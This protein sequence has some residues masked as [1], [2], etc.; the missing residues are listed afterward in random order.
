M[1]VYLLNPPFK[2]GFVRCGRWQGSTARG[3]TLDYPKWLSYTYGQLDNEGFKVRL[4][5]AIAAKYDLNRIISDIE[6]FR[7]DLLIIET[8]FSSMKND[9]MVNGAIKIES[10]N[11]DIISVLTGPPTVVYPNEILEDTSVNIIARY[12]YDFVVRDLAVALEYGKQLKDID[13]IWYKEGSKIICNKDRSF[14]TSKELD[15]LPFV[16]EIYKKNLN[17]YDYYLSQ[18][19]YPEVQIFS[20][21]GCP[22]NCTFCSW[23]VNL[24]G[25]KIRMRSIQNLADEFEYISQEIPA[26]KEIFLEDDTFTIDKHRVQ[27]FC[28]EIVKRKLRVK[29]SCNSRADLDYETMR[30]MK[31]SGCRLVIVG[32]ESGSNEILKNIKKGTSTEKELQFTEKAKKAGL[33]IHADFIIGLPGE[34]QQTALKTLD[35]INKVEPDIL[36]V[37]IATPI[38]GTDF[39][40]LTKDNGYLLVED[41]SKS[42]DDY[43]YQKCIISYPNFTKEDIEEWVN[44]ILRDYYLN[45]NY[46]ITFIRGVLRGGGIEH[47]KTIMRSS[48]DFMKYIKIFNKG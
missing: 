12:E 10:M 15:K 28:N 16:S 42:I 44:K 41:M 45:P 4:I 26:I 34:T 20:G 30:L 1:K 11:K 14:S 32:Y 31:K 24:T 38:P 8:N 46:A 19:L 40:E 13:G 29:W 27:E 9:L 22:H 18:S 7:P 25:K 3:G 21:R 6:Q 47:V 35:F 43:G 2:K 23:P 5:D 17:I 37:A 48:K 36:Q 39:F 33:L